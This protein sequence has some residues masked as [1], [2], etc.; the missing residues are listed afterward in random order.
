APMRRPVMGDGEILPGEHL[1]ALILAIAVSGTGN[2]DRLAEIVALVD[3]GVAV[4]GL[5]DETP[6]VVVGRPPD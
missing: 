3:R 1:V 2:R 6:F 5:G 4:E